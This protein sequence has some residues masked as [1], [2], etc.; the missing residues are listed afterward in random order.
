MFINSNQMSNKFL[1]AKSFCHQITVHFSSL[2]NII[3]LQN[4]IDHI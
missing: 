3:L 1:L 4:P 2:P